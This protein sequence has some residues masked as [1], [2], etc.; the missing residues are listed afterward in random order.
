MLSTTHMYKEQQHV[1]RSYKF[2]N[3]TG[4]LNTVSSIGTIN[5]SPKRTESP[6]M[7][8]VEYYKLG[9]IQSMEGNVSVGNKLETAIAGGW[10]YAQGSNRYMMVAEKS[11]AV[12]ILNPVTDTFDLVYTFSTESPR[13]S[14]CNMN[15]GVVFTNGYDD[16]V[17]Y[18]KGRHTLLTGEISG[19]AD[20]TTITGNLTNFTKELSV[21]D[22]IEVGD[23][24]T[25]Q[26]F[27][28]AEIKSDTEIE[29]TTSITTAFSSEP[30]YLGEISECNAYLVNSEDPDMKEPIRGLAIQY[31]KGRLWIGSGST[32]YYSQLGQYN[33][34]DTNYGAGGIANAY[35]DTSEVKALGLFSDYMLVHKE[36]YTYSISGGND[37]DSWT[38]APY[39]NI[40]CESQQSWG[41]SNSK[42]FVFSKSN[43]GIYPL[44]QITIFSDRYV[45]NELSVKIRD[46]FDTLRQAD[47]K[48]IFIVTYP[49]K[50]WLLFYMP[51]EGYLG[52]SRCFIWDFQTSTWLQRIVPQNV[53]V[54]FNYQ[55]RPYIGTEDGLVL[56]EFYGKNFNGEFL[57]AYWKSPWFCFMDNYYFKTF[58]QFSVQTSQ[59]ENNNFFIRGYRDGQSQFYQRQI[60]NNIISDS[61][62]LIWAGL[63]QDGSEVD[64]N[65]FTTWDNF[66]WVVAGQETRRF[67]LEQN[68]FNTYQVEFRTAILNQGFAIYGFN[69]QD[70][71]FAETPWGLGY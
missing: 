52:S 40:T 65:N 29:T 20:S 44:S 36:Y 71:E 8:N 54:V 14:F 5:Q 9:G 67:P 70:V 18:Q 4:G 62:A 32:V 25:P 27:T 31:Y 68:Y 58:N 26:I 6:D 61:N 51:F 41:V 38:M 50:R 43:M 46:S 3:L 55:N 16:P 13:V 57:D 21:G 37:P 22:T 24:D 34:W 39:S 45:G 28:I 33:K 15:D 47:L 53:S 63:G 49:A 35:N 23:S 1:G 64:I 66:D 30:F 2:E 56:L 48:N 7:V 60:S 11:G 17:F 59:D 69:F 42:Y 12:R 19:E 10:E